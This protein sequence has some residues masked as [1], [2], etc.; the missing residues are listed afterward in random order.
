M[1]AVT[2]H[3][4]WFKVSTDRS[5]A[6]RDLFNVVQLC[7]IIVTK[8]VNGLTLIDN[9]LMRFVQH[10]QDGCIMPYLYHFVSTHSFNTMTAR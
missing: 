8:I 5:T 1:L 4:F 2:L 6:F 9:M 10:F 3:T 7:S